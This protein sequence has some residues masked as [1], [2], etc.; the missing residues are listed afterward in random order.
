MLSK[1]NKSNSLVTGL[2]HVDG[3]SLLDSLAVGADLL[4]PVGPDDGGLAGDDA[5]VVAEL[6]AVA[7]RGEEDRRA[8]ELVVL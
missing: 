1:E 3:G 4:V 2:P 7:V 8:H 5:V 6:D